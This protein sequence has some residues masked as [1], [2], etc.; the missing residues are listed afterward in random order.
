MADE[1]EPWVQL[2]TRIPISLR[3]K[4]KLHCITTETT[5]V[6]FIVAAIEEKIGRDAKKRQRC[7]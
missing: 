5:M 7:A 3:R 4:M 1:K 6:D 2:A